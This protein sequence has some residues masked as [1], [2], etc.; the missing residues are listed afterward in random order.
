MFAICPE[1]NCELRTV[2]QEVFSNAQ[3][4]NYFFETKCSSALAKDTAI[5][6]EN[7]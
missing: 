6:L 2:I 7:M 4:Y 5:I 3:V 1:D